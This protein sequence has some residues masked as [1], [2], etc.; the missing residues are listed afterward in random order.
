MIRKFISIV[1][2]LCFFITTYIIFTNIL[3]KFGYTPKLFINTLNNSYR[4]T[5]TY[6]K[7]INFLI[8][9]VDPRNDWLEHNLDTDTIILA[10][11]DINSNTLKL[12]SLPR[13]LW[14]ENS[15][16][17]KIYFQSL[18]TQ[19]PLNIT[20]HKFTQITGQSI[21][22]IFIIN[23]DFLHNLIDII[24]YVDVELPSAF[25]DNQYPNPAYIKDP[26]NNP[27]P[28]IT[29]G[30]SS[31]INRLDASNIDYYVRSRKSS[32]NLS[33]SSDTGRSNRQKLLFNALFLRL[34]QK[35]VI[36]NI[37]KIASLYHLWSSQINKDI[38]DENLISIFL[39]INKNLTSLKI[40]S[41]NIPIDSP[42]PILYHPNKFTNNAWVYLPINN[43][44][45]NI[46]KYLDS[47]L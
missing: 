31:G 29:I 40:S 26:V 17:N 9:G 2:F 19:N 34:F 5:H 20:K 22:H 24:G 8:L 46:K 35:D 4:N 1:L 23:T 6:N 13:D 27:N 7:R 44:Y 33:E 15:R 41:L 45:S 28:Y 36:T 16:I 37:N 39:L 11:L 10:S 14:F 21:D 43:D 30:F 3:G 47:I 32:D 12:V 18:Q 42:N 25:T 38:T